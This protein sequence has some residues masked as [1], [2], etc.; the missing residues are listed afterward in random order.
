MTCPLWPVALLACLAAVHAGPVPFQ[1]KENVF[2]YTVSVGK[3][4]AQ[5]YR[6]GFTIDSDVVVRKRSDATY[7]VKVSGFALTRFSQIGH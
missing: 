4:T 7:F 5:T 6:S 1:G 3:E 2:K